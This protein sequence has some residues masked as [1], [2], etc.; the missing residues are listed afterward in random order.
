MNDAKKKLTG[1]ARGALA[2]AGVQLVPYVRAGALD[3][4]HPDLEPA[5]GTVHTRCAPFTMTTVERMYSLWKSVHHLG[6]HGVEGDIVECGVW[7]GGSSMVAAL[8][9]LE[10]GDRARRLHLYDTFEGMSAPTDQDVSIGGLSAAE[11][12]DRIK[13]DRDDPVL[14]YA[15]LE[16]V[17]RNMASTGFPADR[18]DYVQGK[19]E[20]TIPGH[21]PEKI[22]LLRLDTDWYES[23]KHELDHLWSR[24]VPG[25][26]LIIDD[27]GDWIG[28]RRAVDEFFAG[29][30]DAP[31][32]VRVDATGRIGV[33][34][35]DG[36]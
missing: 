17:K 4:S 15:S 20:E 28:A 35:S 11:N 2:R 22:A 6:A 7:R 10:Q 26:I 13:Q 21:A 18:V 19:V 32:L 25:G 29:R 5:F 33:K 23:T 16:E 27:Y 31:L 1:Y 8:A 12:W 3:R 14:A 9:L 30:A 24:L 36:A 34:L